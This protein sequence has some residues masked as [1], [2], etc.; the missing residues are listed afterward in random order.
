MA[1]KN[2]HSFTNTVN[3]QTF[4]ECPLGAGAQ[5]WMLVAGGGKEGPALEGVLGEGGDP[6]VHPLH[7]GSG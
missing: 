7:K 5:G 2:F 3:P 4:S 1:D 6:Q